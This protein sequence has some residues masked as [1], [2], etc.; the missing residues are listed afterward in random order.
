VILA[1]NVLIFVSSSVLGQ[2]DLLLLGAKVNE[3]IVAGEIWRLV[4]AVF[5]HVDV[6]HIAFNSYALFVFGVQVERR[7][8]RVRFPLIYLASG[9]AGSSLSFLLSPYPSV[10][11]SGAIFGLIGVLGAYLYRYRDWLVAGRARLGN[12]VSILLYNL[13]YGLMIPAVDN[14]AHIGG[15]LAGLLLGWTLAPRYEFDS[16]DL[17][18]GRMPQVL[19]EGG[20]LQWL[21]G[22][23]LVSGLIGLT[24]LGGFFRWSG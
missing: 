21:Q 14:W 4:T 16:S 13:V 6:F 18:S 12:I 11:A 19:D 15:L 10:G 24:V 7:F 17:F 22:L 2:I 9:I 3:A 20:P 23:I 8:G 5:L 1:V